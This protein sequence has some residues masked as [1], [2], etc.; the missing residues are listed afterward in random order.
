MDLIDSVRLSINFVMHASFEND[1]ELTP[2]NYGCTWQVR[3][4]RAI[5]C[6]AIR[7]ALDD[8]NAGRVRPADEVIAELRQRG[9]S[10]VAASVD[11]F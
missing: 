11:L 9:L 7:S 10:K 2:E 3:Q 6:A 8:L 1:D 4:E 5:S